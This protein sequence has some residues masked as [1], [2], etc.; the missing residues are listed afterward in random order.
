MKARLFPRLTAAALSL[1]LLFTPAAQA[2]TLDQAKELLQELYVD[3]VPE[4]VLAQPTIE[5]MLEALGD[6]YTQYFTAEEYADFTASM[7]DTSL[8]GIGVVSQMMEDGLLISRIVADSPAERGG[9]TVGDLITAVD[10][11]PTAGEDSDLVTSWIRGEEGTQVQITY[12]RDGQAHTITLI[13]TLVV[14]PATTG[15]LI[16]GHIGYIECTTFGTE[17]VD[18]FREII[19]EIGGQVTT[20]IVDLR[21]NT[22]GVTD[23]ATMAASLF[24]GGGI[25]AYLRDGEGQY[26]AYSSAN[27]GAISGNSLT[28]APVIILVNE[29]TA[30]ASELFSS[31]IRSHGEGIVIGTRTYGKGVAQTVLDQDYFPDYFPDGDAIKITSYRFYSPDGNTT[32]QLGVIPDLLV[33][34]KDAMAVA[35]LLAGRDPKGE[36]QGTLR[37]DLTWRWYVD[38]DTASD[39]DHRETFATLLNAIP[40]EKKLWL[41]TIV[42]G[43]D[44]ATAWKQTSVQALCE[45]YALDYQPPLFPD[46]E[47]TRYPA[48]LSDLKTFGL[49]NGKGD[50]LFHPQD[51]LTRAELCQM[52]Y[53]AL[54]C[55]QPANES[56]FS[57]VK[58]DDWFAPAVIAMANIG[59]VNG[60]GNGTFLPYELVDHQQFI[61]V[62]ARLAQFLNM[63]LYN[64]AKFAEVGSENLA[65]LIPYDGWAKSSAWLLSCSQ[66]NFLGQPIT[67]L[68]D[69]AFNIDPKTATTREEAVYTFHRILTYVDIL[70]V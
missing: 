50:G 67:L 26:Y 3:E 28:L 57:D 10:G 55:A 48:A 66:Q 64:T 42:G 69:S 25:M 23:A 56:P 24:T 62:M 65:G 9:L 61:T 59:L 8:V 6:P 1:V 2:L 49:I 43:Y 58:T 37:V 36:T 19:N 32:D 51:S 31:A 68:W 41:G 60:V 13:R 52:L 53:S 7:S 12:L 47:E 4:S 46:H 44:D 20:W 63:G 54:N 34:E 70:P 38:L 27:G 15:E 11:R 22:G 5:D 29:Y 40:T 17:T 35:L 21:S 39:A 33:D 18:H 30:S 14:V 16:D 45:T